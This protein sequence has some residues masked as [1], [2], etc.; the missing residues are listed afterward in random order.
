MFLALFFALVCTLAQVQA[1]EKVV[2]G[3]PTDPG[4]YPWMVGLLNSPNSSPY[5][6]GILVKPNVVL[7]AAHCP[8]PRVVQIGCHQVGASDCEYINTAGSSIPSNYQSRPVPINDFRIINLAGSSRYSV[9]PNVA[10][11]SWGSLAVG[12]DITTIGFGTTSAGG[13]VSRRL[14]EA[15]VSYV[16]NDECASAYR[17]TGTTVDNSM[18]CGRS[19]GKDACQGDSGGPLV[20]KCSNGRDILI[21]VVSWGIGCADPSFPGVYGRVSFADQVGF[22]N[23]LNLATPSSVNNLCS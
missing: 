9:I 17:G 15:T 22:L 7:S 8:S 3:T 10:D 2:G 19:P 5:C 18:I 11:S 6:G 13:S 12:T 16:S 21:G 14:L 4:R 1:G 23:P 20:V